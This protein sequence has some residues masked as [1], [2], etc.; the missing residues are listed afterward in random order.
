ML[1]KYFLALDEHSSTR[2]KEHRVHRKPLSHL[3]G[4]SEL[5]DLGNSNGPASYKEDTK[6]EDRL[7]LEAE[8]EKKYEDGYGGNQWEDGPTGGSKGG[9][10]STNIQKQDAAEVRN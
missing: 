6:L 7:A 1:N 8:E 3:L 5:G 2:V 9:S 10:W 4:M